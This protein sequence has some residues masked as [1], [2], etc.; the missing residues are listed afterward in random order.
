MNPNSINVR[1]GELEDVIG[2]ARHHQDV[3]I[4][5]AIVRLSGS[6]MTNGSFLK[7]YLAAQ[8]LPAEVKALI[9]PGEDAPWVCGRVQRVFS[10]PQAPEEDRAEKSCMGFSF[11]AAIPEGDHLVGIPFECTD[12]Y[13]KSVLIFSGNAPP[14]EQID[15]VANS[16]WQILLEKPGDLPEYMDHFFHMGAG[17]EV[18]FGVRDGEPFMEEVAE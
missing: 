2:H 18:R 16:F 9:R 14:Q 1:F 11:L 7:D 15:R 3:A 12:Y 8:K 5:P 10:I 13:G 6:R 4:V 17:V